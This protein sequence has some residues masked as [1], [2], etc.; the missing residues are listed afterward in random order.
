VVDPVVVETDVFPVEVTPGVDSD[1]DGLTDTEEKLVYGTDSRLPD[2]DSDG[3]LDGNEVFH[4]Y[5]PA[6]LGT[7]LESGVV[8]VITSSK[9]RVA[10]EFYYPVSWDIQ[11]QEGGFMMDAQTGEGFRVTFFEK[12]ES[13]I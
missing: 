13:Y 2:T 11:E 5:N 7:L 3:F 9:S 10:Y 12:L 8:K 1:S 6:S 4:R